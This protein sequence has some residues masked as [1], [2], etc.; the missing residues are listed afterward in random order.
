MLLSRAEPGR[1]DPDRLMRLFDQLPPAEQ[2]GW[3][4]G[5]TAAS[6]RCAFD[7]IP[8]WLDGA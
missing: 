1:P 3:I 7:E 4:A 2:D 5:A 6:D 8:D